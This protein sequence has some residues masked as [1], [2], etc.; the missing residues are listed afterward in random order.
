MPDQYQNHLIRE[1]SP[2]LLQHA[3]NPVEWYPWG[4]EAFQKAKKENKPVFLSIGYSTCHW[5]HVMAHESFEDPDV[6]KVINDYF[7]PIK[8]DREER[9]DIDHVY[10][11]CVMAMTGQG[12]WPL[13]AFLTPDK[14][15][16]YGGTYFPP[17]AKWGSAGLVDIM[18]SVHQM[19][20]SDS[21]KIIESSESLTQALVQQIESKQTGTNNSLTIDIFQKAYQ[22]FLH[23]YDRRYGGFG[24]SPKFPSSHNLSFLLRY[25]KRFNEPMAQEIVENTLIKMARGGM[26]DQL[27]GGFHRYSTDQYWQVPHFEKMLYDQAIL[28]RTYLEAYQLTK[29]EFFAQ[30]ARETFDYVLR[31]M[32]DPQG[33]FY[34]AQDA[35]SLDPDH[36]E[37]SHKKEGAF[38]VW[39]FQEI[40]KVLETEAEIFNYH[41]GI[42]PSGNAMIDPHGEFIGKN[43]LYADDNIEKT[44]Q[45]FKKSSQEV[46]QI[47]KSAR[48]K[49]FKVRSQRP[50]CHLDDKVLVDWNGLMISSL[51][52]G[53]RVL[54]E[55][56]YK[57]AAEK[58][59]QFIISHL[60]DKKGR[61][62]HRY[63]DQES[64]ILGTLT[65]Y[66]F[67]I[68]GLL[69]LYE[70]TFKAEYLI[71]ARDLADD[72]I[73]LF[74]DKEHGGFYLTATDSEEL[75]LKHKEIYDGAIPSGN[76]IAAL[77][78]IR[79]AHFTFD[80]KWQSILEKLFKSFSHEI[81][82]HPSVYAQ[83]LIAFDFS[84]GS[85]KEIILSGSQKDSTIQQ[86]IDIIYSQFAPRKALMLHDT[87]DLSVT[88]VNSFIKTQVPIKGKA[89][90]YICENHVCQSPATSVEDLIKI[91]E[92]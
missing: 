67:F 48:E 11:N 25:A 75:L 77:N 63:R 1:K 64:A 40:L 34:C 71:L 26:Y 79:L 46:E 54:K 70:A 41:F 17:Y 33:G 9:P 87:E 15:P 49:L 37:D 12:G 35:D 65:D 20:E 19:W 29:N 89:T 85:T 80:N 43:V 66:A 53:S 60:M 82:Q 6:A 58:S 8:V 7:I 10:M 76:S 24:E 51:A 73:E 55:P 2:Y 61:L 91:L 32:Q 86:M 39:S 13:T 50:S 16:F 30:V 5:C 44:A 31:E 27:G 57:E 36:A 18:N 88:Q 52:F 74:E 42:K 62:L 83:M 23:S 38:Y 69:D 45:H 90:A 28:T 14:K 22:Q 4:D 21:A 72:M 3:N 59:A 78:L 56:K 68:D 47:L 81:S 84:L 92:K